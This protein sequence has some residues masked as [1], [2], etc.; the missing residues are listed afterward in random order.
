MPIFRWFFGLFVHI[1]PSANFRFSRCF[2]VPHF[3]LNSIIK[4]MEKKNKWMVA[5]LLSAG[6]T[7]VGAGIGML[8][9]TTDAGGAIGFGIGLL[10]MGV[11]LVVYR[12]R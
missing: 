4:Y 2:A 12:Q 1:S 5:G 7:V 6:C 11:V 3:D 10:A 8:N 9:N